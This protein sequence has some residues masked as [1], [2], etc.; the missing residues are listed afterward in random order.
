MIC[1]SDGPG[2][3]TWIYV[4]RANLRGDSSEINEREPG[5]AGGYNVIVNRLPD[6]TRLCTSPAKVGIWRKLV[7]APPNRPWV[8]AGGLRLEAI[9]QAK[10]GKAGAM[11]STSRYHQR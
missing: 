8:G 10:S 3:R 7:T 4:P 5:V 9:N 11:Q 6:Q 2:G 1:P